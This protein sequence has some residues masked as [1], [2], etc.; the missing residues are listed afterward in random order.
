MTPRHYYAEARRYA[1]IAA[2]TPLRHFD[3]AADI[4]TPPPSSRPAIADAVARAACCFSPAPPRCPSPARAT[5]Y[6]PLLMLLYE[7]R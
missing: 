3:D 2:I 1:A 7:P 6:L 4:F 5:P